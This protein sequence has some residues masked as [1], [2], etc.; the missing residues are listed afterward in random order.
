MKQANI[1]RSKKVYVIISS[2]TVQIINEPQILFNQLYYHRNEAYIEVFAV[3]NEDEAT[4]FVIQRYGY[5]YHT[6]C[7]YT[8]RQFPSLPLAGSYMINTNVD[9]TPRWIPVP[10]NNYEKIFAISY[11]NGF[12]TENNL[13]DLVYLLM[14][15]DVVYPHVFFCW[16]FDYAIRYAFNEYIHRFYSRYD[17]RKNKISYPSKQLILKSRFFD[18]Y[19][20]EREKQIKEIHDPLWRL[21]SYGLL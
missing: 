3:D 21:R 18:P 14:D 12:G 4:I 8:N 10:S 9:I 15:P 17:A 5:L 13:S 7:G 11:I 20:M 19:F 1:E 6:S 2:T 16:N